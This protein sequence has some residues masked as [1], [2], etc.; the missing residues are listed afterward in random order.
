MRQ[1]L[2]TE[3]SLKMMKNIFYFLLKAL[4]VLKLSKFLSWLFGHV[5][6]IVWLKR[7]VNKQ[8]PNTY[9]LISLE[10]KA[11]RQWNLVS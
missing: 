11:I 6:K 7:I 9:S 5:E 10:V 1:F 8:L 3:S 2:A 4:F